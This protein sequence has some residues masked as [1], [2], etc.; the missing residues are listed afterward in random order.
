MSAEIEQVPD[1]SMRRNKSLRLGDGL[2][3][4][5]NPFSDPRGFMRLFSSIV[6]IPIRYM[7]D[8]RHQLPMGDRIATQ[9]ISDDLPRLS[10]MTP[11]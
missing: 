6:G 3:S 5:H 1:C 2:E 9:L 8:L 7:N 11:Q 10:T 4:T